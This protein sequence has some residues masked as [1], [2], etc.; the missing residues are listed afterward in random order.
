MQRLYINLLD[1]DF[2]ILF[3]GHLLKVRAKINLYLYKFI[4]NGLAIRTA[5]AG[6]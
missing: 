3:H 5:I 4:S 1:I 6:W 2:G